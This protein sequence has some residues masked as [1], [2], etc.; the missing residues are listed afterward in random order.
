M[1][2]DPELMEK[3]RQWNATDRPYP[4]DRCIHQIFEDQAAKTPDAIAVVFEDQ[5]LT[6]SQLNA[7]ANQLAHYLRQQGVRADTPVGICMDRSL[8][9]I[10]A[11]YG[12][13]KAGGAYVPVDPMYPRDRMEHIVQEGEI[14]ILL[15]QAVHQ[16]KVDGLG[17]VRLNL[18]EADDAL[19]P[20][21]LTNPMWSVPLG[22][23]AYIIYTSGST[24]KP[25]GV[26]NEHKGIL[27]RLLWMQETFVLDERDRILQKTPYS[28]DVSVWEFFW[29]LM[30]GARLVVARPGGHKDPDYL[31]QT[32]VD[33][34]ITTL[35]FVP[36]MLEIY[37]QHPRVERCRSVRQVFCSGE[38]LGHDLQQSFFRRMTA[39]L[40]NLYG[41]TEAAVDVS[42]WA[43][44][45][46]SPLSFVPIG[47]PVSNTQL[48]I[49]DASMSPV[50]PGAEGELYIGGVQVARGY[51]NRP[52]LT[53]E[54]FIR[55][56]F[57][58]D[59][60][61]R[62]YK[63]GDICRWLEDGNIEYLG[64]ADDQVKIRGFRIELGEIECVL[65]GHPSVRQAVVMAREDE[66]GQKYL[67]GYVVLDGK[68]EIDGEGL[69][70]HLGQKLPE[71]MVPSVILEIQSIPLT[72]S[73]KADRKSLPKPFV[74]EQ[75]KREGTLPQTETEKRLASI[76]MEILGIK[77]VHLEDHFFRLGGHS[78]K[79]IQVIYRVQS[80]F[81]LQIPVSSLFEHP[82]LVDFAGVVE[83][84]R[85]DDKNRS[86]PIPRVPRDKPIPQSFAQKRLWFT[87]QLSR[88]TPVYN[89]S[90]MVLIDGDLKL[91]L[92]EKSIQSLLARHEAFRT[93]FDLIDGQAVQCIA[94]TIPWKLLVEE[95]SSP[96]SS[97]IEP[98]FRSIAKQRARQIFDPERGPLFDFRL[99]KA[100]GDRYALL[101]NMH[102]LI[103][104]GWSIGI[105][106]E[107]LSE[108][109]SAF[110]ERRPAS[111]P[112]LPVQYA[113][114]AVA[115]QQWLPK[116]MDRDYDY[117]K[118]QLCDSVSDITLPADHPRPPILTHRGRREEW[119]ISRHIYANMLAYCS[120]EQV[121][122]YT[123]LVSIY[124]ALLSRITGITELSIGSNIA[125]RTHRDMENII[126]FFVNTIVMRSSFRPDMRF[127]QYLSLMKQLCQD[128]QYHQELPYDILVEKL[129]PHREAGRNL[130]FQLGFIYQ[131]ARYWKANLLD[132]NTC[133]V[134]LGTGTSMIDMMLFAEE[135]NQGLLL[136]AEYNTD[137][138]EE[139][140][141]RRFLRLYEHVL[142]SVI[143]DPNQKI[144]EIGLLTQEDAVTISSWNA[145]DRP[146][147][148][149][150]CI[151]KL[152]EDQA[153]KTPEAIA[154]QFE[155]QMLTY[156]QLNAKANQLAHYLRQRGVGPD[157]PIGIC[158]DRS[159][160]MIVALVAILKAG[161][162]YV[163]LDPLYPAER[164]R[165][166]AQD[167]GVK[168]IL[169]DAGLQAIFPDTVERIDPAAT[170]VFES[171]PA[172]NP[173]CGGTSED[174][175]YIVFTSGSTGTP[176]GVAVPHRGVV[177]LLF[178]TDYME[179]GP[180]LVM[181]QLAPVSFD[182]S[183]LEIWGPL[184]HGGRCVLY[185]GRVPEMDRLQQTLQSRQVN[186]L[187]LTA[188]LFNLVID[189]RP[190]ILKTVA[191]V[192]TGGEV[193]SVPHVRK[194]LEALPEVQWVNGYGP[195][196]ST[197]FT[198]CYR[199]PKILPEQLTSIPIGRPIGNTQVYILDS[200][201]QVVPIGVAGELYIGGDGLA[202]GYVNR[203]ELTAER[204]VHN[205][206][207]DDMTSRLYKTG[208]LCRWLG[209]GTIEY[210]GRAD[211]QVKIR[212]IRIELGEIENVL[213]GHP[214]VRQAVVIAREDVPG[215]KNLTGYV[216]LDGKGRAGG[217]G[218]RK[219]LA[220][221]L[222][223]YMV[224]SV[225]MEL[226]SIPLTA[227]GKADRKN[228]P[229]PVE[230]STGSEESLP[231][232]ETEIKLAEIWRQLLKRPTIDRNDHFFRLGGHSLLAAELFFRLQDTFAIHLPI[233]LIFQAPTLGRLAAAIDEALREMTT[234]DI[235]LIKSGGGSY[236]VF[237][238][239]GIGGH[240]LSF[241]HL[242]EA[243]QIDCPQYG[244]NLRGLDGQ[245]EPQERIEEMASYF[246]DLVRTVQPHGPYNLCGFSFGGRVAFEM[247][248]QL[249]TAGERIGFLGLIG[250]TAPGYPPTSES[251]WKHNAYRL[252]D[253]GRL[254]PAN[255]L[256]YVVHKLRRIS[257]QIG[258]TMSNRLSG[259]R[260]QIQSALP[261]Q[262]QVVRSAK[263]AWYRYMPVRR[264][265]G[266]LSVFRESRG[267]SHLYARYDDPEYGWGKYV[268]GTIHTRSIECSHLDLFRPP[269]VAV[270]G[271]QLERRLQ[272]TMEKH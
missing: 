63:T 211:D 40:H 55:D 133:T 158:M 92:L 197:T 264:F 13:L 18:E 254:N 137:L 124:S 251:R 189:T 107:E 29:P 134:E 123:L 147:P 171:Y 193:L 201:L 57:S 1:Q 208:D 216:V 28:F 241:Y 129:N 14:S 16:S 176:K 135:N 214:S 181:L 215:Q 202:R 240:T 104:D 102:H 23:L 190:E 112:E 138:Y 220:Q 186:A 244:L 90:Y 203:P 265:V 152:F 172:D 136:R 2:T 242:A 188:S 21:A 155:D 184:L 246:I 4:Q 75:K 153:A 255:Q 253:F 61:S 266:D 187:W 139:T 212:G 8:E 11:L 256:R 248:L 205:P 53:A 87:D 120:R 37:L 85:K 173:P 110:R 17:T 9:M 238:L 167:V 65:R 81:D 213:R 230:H 130:F 163:P 258:R 192:L 183:T 114:Y 56:L 113:D 142:E 232:T 15:S 59:P 228:L 231:Q 125:G 20:Y 271:E 261:N 115:Q 259:R 68:G 116:I 229:R 127:S 122:Q 250:A 36:S 233:H 148:R 146:Y 66:P 105:L 74:G 164:L 178:G 76:W 239:P 99:L 218:L 145:T 268:D 269:H 70:K 179:F 121:T 199:I 257:A 35:H 191:T 270:L 247:A 149:D 206:F 103:T 73:G 6:Y 170:E 43:C 45:A 12:I 46:D 249:Q 131:D 60:K 144:D 31:I 222:P 64:R 79:A 33:R 263:R 157:V 88:E 25:K 196:E 226:E 154:V 48:F 141:I 219:Y 27:N 100:G 38:A 117:W 7:K 160:D 156:S 243:M 108:S 106:M 119:K 252:L 109:Y 272:V 207:S 209:D 30:F 166:M 19:S 237:Y 260:V 93:T 204:F 165:F 267:L 182:A 223:E 210:I 69:R 118:R 236:P 224:P 89:I 162:G 78:L 51:V 151:H 42:W 132:L 128:I 32:I 101:L 83:G 96:E 77:S 94:P 150:R 111:L 41:P 225:I 3:V 50:T 49:L 185:P 198:C 98:L 5:T 195:T 54:R 10:I 82:T 159:L 26:M 97:P 80:Q 84:L 91:D 262:Q 72:T 140:T 24:G 52:E 168:L 126:G 200:R 86:Q 174:L 221:K 234:R 227:S 169:A 175:A 47:K 39:E 44:R 177:R 34:Q 95:V 235:V 180:E 217:E 58:E 245:T 62:L 67:A 161:G 143:A 22:S 194:A 71:Y